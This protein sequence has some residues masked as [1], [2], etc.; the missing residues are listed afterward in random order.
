MSKR[1]PPPCPEPETG[2]QYWRSLD[3]WA[4]TPEFR[5]WA[6]RE[7]PDGAS[8]LKDPVSRRSFMKLMSASLMLAGV[9]VT[10]CR[11]PTENILPFNK[12]PE[13]YTHGVPQYFATAMPVRGTAIPLV[14]KSHEGRPVKIEGNADHP[15]N[16]GGGPGLAH[17]GTDLYAQASILNLYDPDRARRVLFKG[18][19]ATPEKA[20]DALAAIGRQFEA[21]QGKGLAF[22]LERSS[23]PSRAR[24]RQQLSAKLPQARWCVYEPVDF[25][26]RRQA[27][28]L[29]F[30]KSVKPVYHLAKARRIL[31]LDCDFLGGEEEASQL[32]RGFAAGR[33]LAQPTD[34]L[35]R[36][37][38]AEG[39][40]TLTGAAADHRLRLAPSQIFPLT[41]LIFAEFIQQ[42]N[43]QANNPQAGALADALR[44]K[45][46]GLEADARQWAAVCVKDLLAHGGNVAVLAGQQQPL[47]VH[48]LAQA[49]N[50]YVARA[51]GAVTWQ[52]V[53]EAESETISELA[54]ALNGG[55]VQTLVILGGNPVYNAPA[56]L[57][58]ART[59]RQA[60]LVVRLGYYEDETTPLCDWQ[61]PAAH[62][63]ESWG[64]ARTGDGTL[65]P[66]QPLIQPLFGGLTDLEL[67]ARIGGLPAAKPYEIVRETFKAL[68]PPG[69]VEEQWKRFL[70][71]GHL[72]ASAAGS[73]EVEIDWNAA[74]TAILQ[75]KPSPAPSVSA[76]D[77]VF[78]RAHSIDDG[79][80]LNNGWLQELPDPITKINWDNVIQLS[81]ATAKALGV[82]VQDKNDTKLQVPVVRVELNG[83]SIEGPAWITPGLADNVIGL[84]LGYGRAAGAAGR[85]GE[86]TGYNAYPLRTSQ[87][88]GVA[89]GGKL[90]LAG[91]EYPLASTQNHWAMEGRAI[92][93]EAN[94][95]EYQK[96]PRFA[97]AMNLEEPPIVE[98]LYSNPLAAAAK[99]ADHQWGMSVDLNACVGCAACT[100]ACQSENNI[101]IVGKD[102]V[103]RN[104]EMHW[105]RIDRYFVGDIAAPQ[106]VNQPMMC[107][108]CEAAPCEN[109]CPV[110]AT[111]H[112][113][114]GLNVMAYNR[115]VG[116]RYC[117]NN[118][119]FK[120]RRFNFFDYSRRTLAELKG[121]FY[122]S[123][124][125]SRANG[126]WYMKRWWN[127]RESSGFQ[128]YEQWELLKL[129]KNPEVT[130][131][132]RGVMEKCTFCIQRI[133][134]AKITQKVKAG[135]SGDVRVPD[136][137]IKTACEQA[138]PAG[139]IVF[140]NIQDP[141]SQVSQA[142][143]N[144]RTYRV[145]DY[146]NIKPR[147][148]Y[149]ARV[150]NPNP[151]MPDYQ[152]RPQ[153]TEAFLRH[154]GKLEGHETGPGTPPAAHPEPK[155]AH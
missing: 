1:I 57:D 49:L 44:E 105:I 27:A 3:E 67:M 112:D 53:S 96:N 98:P 95:A 132:M 38:V 46:R 122:P 59:M 50:F 141:A 24:L 152:P 5:E 123:P 153:S 91:R 21:T 142:K 100:M 93:R 144:E 119:P 18:Q 135:A 7:F 151:D 128:P 125:I 42:S 87:A 143:A 36:L 52:A 82:V 110:N 90:S 19:N 41:C 66:V 9:G 131:R 31:S 32:I 77:V 92:V 115:C 113:D 48:L 103:R 14:V 134:S 47:E 65:V 2:R 26:H 33:K 79:R 97:Q 146:L 138:C 108:H 28:T 137:T 94:L 23:S 127:N 126:E 140:G 75:G 6:A 74:G 124:L 88:P 78:A 148:T 4:G 25:D 73:V 72:A 81:Q 35:S 11:R 58:W 55:A 56:D 130:V 118:C 61:L 155:G 89:N 63:L 76:L 111:V 101:P 117:S 8:E 29:V 136:G 86:A 133:E 62:Y 147:V 102:Q 40:M 54:T 60:G 16:A 17:G 145:L 80:Y 51:G 107:Q 22:L 84:T 43:A 129:V 121:P 116:T 139:A 15:V 120:V 68:A 109:V 20:F 99:N 13:G 45:A 104:R 34:E 12:M 10:G 83:R 71:D 150:R 69:V 114:E 39:L 85:V 30:G 37:Y 70:H 149:L 64:D 106:M 154:G